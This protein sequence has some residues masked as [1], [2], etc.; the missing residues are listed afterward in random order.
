MNTFHFT[1]VVSS[2][3]IY[4][5]LA[6]QDSL[7]EHCS[8]YHLYALCADQTAYDVLN[9]L[10]LKNITLILVSQ[11]EKGRLYKAKNDRNHHEYCWTLKA[12][13]LNYIMN[14]YKDT[15]YYAHL[16]SDLY[17]FSDPVQIVNEAPTASLFL[18]DHNFSTEFLSSYETS[19][20]YN[21]GFVC[22]KKDGVARAAVA[23]WSEMCFEK[24]SLKADA[25]K[26]IYGDQRYVEKWPLLFPNVHNINSKGANVAQWNVLGFNISEKAGQ[27][28]VENDRLIFYHFSGLDILSKNEY[29][30][31][32]FFRAEDIPLNLIYM[33][34]VISLSQQISLVANHF[35]DFR[36]GIANRI[37]VPNIHRVEL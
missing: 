31:C 30:L 18:T 8:D 10:D 6:M 11:L 33:P 5:F 29:S 36:D 32:T 9:R 1:S 24:C 22:C 7:L 34:Y 2:A 23:W 25:K 3:Y 20:K 14:K 17:F 13:F 15:C 35:P 27:V 16:D 4:K 28:F 21:T 19:G 12:F 37:F 26:E